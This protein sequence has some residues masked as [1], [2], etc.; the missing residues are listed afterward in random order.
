MMTSEIKYR[1]DEY[2]IVERA[3]VFLTWV[4]H[5][6]IGAQLTGRCSIFG[7]ILVIGPQEHEE[8]GFLKLEFDEQLRKLP[9]WTKTTYYCLAS[10]IR[11][12]GTGQSL[13][14]ELKI[15][16]HILKI[17]VVDRDIK[18]PGSFRLGRYRIIIDGNNIIAWQSIGELNRTIGGK[19]AIE[20]GVLFL[21]QNEIES[22]DAQ[23]RRGFFS[24][25]K[26][27]PQWIKLLHG[28]SM[29]LS[30]FVGNQDPGN[31]MRQLGSQRALRLVWVTTY[32]LF[33]VKNSEKKGPPS[34]GYQVPSG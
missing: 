32:Q 27:L 19:C 10:S 14:H 29:D 8:A 3:G 2:I 9:A 7:N 33:R 22:D 17:D 34:L 20:S 16:P 15:H 1:L 5:I 26:L 25:Q 11:K 23:S 6:A 31:L 30:G 18:G 13:A 28:D 24:C 21:G 12:I 4:S